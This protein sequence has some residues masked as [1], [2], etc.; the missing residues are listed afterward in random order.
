M[1]LTPG[2]RVKNYTLERQLGKGASGEVWRAYD[3]TKTVAIKFMNENLMKSASAAKHRE[4]LLREVEALR[5]LEHPNVPTLYDYD[6]DFVRP[7]LAMRYVGGDSYDRLISTG[8]MLKIPLA[9][10]LEA[11]RELAF[12][13]TAAH[14]AGIIHR[15]I[16]PANMTGIENPFLLDF[17]ISL[18]KA[19][20][21]RTQRFVG[22]TL[23]MA[24]DGV[25]DRLSDNY[26]FAVVVFEILF[27][28]HPIYRLGDSVF[29]QFIA[30]MRIQNREWAFPST[31]PLAQLPP[32]LHKADLR[33][34]DAIFERA[35]GSREQRYADLR[36]FVRDLQMA[37]FTA[38]NPAPQHFSSF[39][40]IAPAEHV[41]QPPQ[42]EPEPEPA[43]EISPEESFLDKAFL[44]LP[45][46]KPPPES[47]S[48]TSVEQPT[49]AQPYPA[50][51]RTSEIERE[52]I[53]ID[54]G[55]GGIEASS[56]AQ[57]VE[58][59]EPE[60]R[61]SEFAPPDA[62]TM[63]EIRVPKSPEPE[64]D[65]AGPEDGT[66]ME[67]PAVRPPESKE[68]DRS[69]EFAP[70]D[71]MTMMEIPVPKSVEPEEEQPKEEDRSSEFAPPDAMTMME[72]R[73]PKS[74]EPEEE[75]PKEEDRS[76][77]FAPPDAMTMMEIRV[78]PPAPE[79]EPEPEPVQAEMDDRTMPEI[80]VP[81]PPE[82]DDRTM[83]DIR[84]PHPQPPVA[85]PEAENFT[86]MEM[87]APRVPQAQQNDSFTLMEMQAA[88][89]PK[90]VPDPFENENFTLMEMQSPAQRAGIDLSTSLG[91]DR[92]RRL[93]IIGLIVLVVVI[94]LVVAAVALSNGVR[95]S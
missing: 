76:S 27:G 28:R 29:N 55:T 48:V 20:A 12:A 84:V 75:Q 87:Q 74:V 35:I 14:D 36:E 51:R 7:Y 94:V 66:R 83:P 4:R 33:R 72:I 24:P 3:E 43:K 73:V 60:D 62:M 45:A 26:S 56:D 19:D 79:K 8:E 88:Q 80:R 23:Y 68:E 1:E 37:I 38:E 82:M 39:A 16:K 46:I 17:S 91:G 86:L 61:S 77:E 44:N 50:Q 6:L 65:F 10:R 53:Q 5:K 89:Q 15:D 49:P 13:L 59:E 34:L 69:S 67:I 93:L 63:M 70:P 78:P 58:E 81:K 71:A 30:E 57:P 92:N 85:Q 95:V 31:I 90:P 64:E 40:G 21:E 32:D 54:T 41:S 47:I 2:T 52:S 11:I 42:P 22:T 25:V 18:G 9:R